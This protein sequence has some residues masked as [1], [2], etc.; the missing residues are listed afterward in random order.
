MESMI[1]GVN[2]ND[3]IELM[4]LSTELSKVLARVV[5]IS[6]EEVKM[7]L[8][9]DNTQAKTNK[10]RSHKGKK[11]IDVATGK[12]YKSVRA[13]ARNIGAHGTEISAC[14]RGKIKTVRGHQFKYLDENMKKFNAE[15]VGKKIE[16]DNRAEKVR[17]KMREMEISFDELYDYCG[18]HDVCPPAV[19]A[20]FSH[21]TEKDYDYVITALN[22]IKSSKEASYWVKCKAY[23]DRHRVYQYEIAP[24]L[25]MTETSVSL[26]IRAAD[27]EFYENVVK[28]V[29]MIV[30]KRM[31]EDEES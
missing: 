11:V 4:R 17:D 9:A 7:A 28:A 5:G 10:K 25:G 6:D 8:D 18:K 22:D 23:M 29:N 21:M 31:H 14:C 24:V 1:I 2:T 15:W 19:R 13:A 16:N 30:A 20:M 12:I 3:L 26:T 27:K